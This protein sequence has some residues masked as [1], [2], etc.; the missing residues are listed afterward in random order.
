VKVLFFGKIA[1]VT[2]RRSM[3]ATG[4]DGATLH[5]L[6]DRIF[7]EALATGRVTARDI[8]MSINKT[9][10]TADQSLDEGDEIA[11]FSIFSGG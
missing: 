11:F 1:D 3:T 9:V 10:V 7:A 5:A 4:A 2:G 6:R 8:R